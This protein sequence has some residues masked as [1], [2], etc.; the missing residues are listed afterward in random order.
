MERSRRFRPSQYVQRLRQQP[1]WADEFP[2]LDWDSDSDLTR[3]TVDSDVSSD[4]G[5]A[6]SYN[7]DAWGDWVPPRPTRP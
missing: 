6:D 1:H 4:G 2:W 3:A 7:P 5:S